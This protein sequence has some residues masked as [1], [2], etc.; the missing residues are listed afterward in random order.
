[1]HKS[2]HLLSGKSRKYPQPPR[3]QQNNRQ[4]TQFLPTSPSTQSLNMFINFILLPYLAAIFT[5]FLSAPLGS[6]MSWQRL[7]YFGEAIAHCSLLGVAIGLYFDL[8]IYLG[9]WLI[10]FLLVI[11]LWLIKKRGDNENNSI[12]ATIS[13]I[14]L[15]LGVIVISQMENVRTDLTS[16]LFGDILSITLKD[17]IIISIFILFGLIIIKKI[18]SKL[19]L[20][21]VSP[22][23]AQAEITNANLYDAIFLTLLALFIGLMAQY[24]GLLLVI[25]LLIIPANAG[26]KI[27]KTPENSVFFAITI[28]LTA[29]TI[30]MLL[31][32]KADFALSPSIVLIAGIIYLLTTAISIIKQKT[33]NR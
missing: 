4:R 27:A 24:F 29:I 32:F 25:A 8:P 20:L 2:P 14:A 28:A 10:S 23:I 7:T 15:S 19:I 18:W 1:M 21:T 22:E 13:H 5:A 30:G 11:L 12:L 31:A 6:L 3:I 33:T 9:I 16:Y 17:L 26:A